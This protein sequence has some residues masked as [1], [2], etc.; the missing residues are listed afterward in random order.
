[1]MMT[2]LPRG[3]MPTER[4]LSG[5]ARPGTPVLRVEPRVAS[6]LRPAC[7]LC[8]KPWARVAL[9]ARCS[10]LS[11]KS[12]GD[13]VGEGASRTPPLAEL[14]GLGQGLLM[15]LQ[16]ERADL[17][18]LDPA[19][20]GGENFLKLETT[21]FDDKGDSFKGKV[22]LGRQTDAIV[23][24]AQVTQV[25]EREKSEG[26]SG[27]DL[28]QELLAIQENG[29]KTIGFFGTRNMGFL[30]QQLVEIL[31]YAMVLTE[32]HIYTSGATG[33]NAAVI[34]GALR[35]EKPDLLTVVLPQSLARQP[36][37]SRDLLKDVANVIE[38][39]EN[40]HMALIDASRLCNER[41]LKEVV[42]VICFAFHDSNLLLETCREAK[43]LRKMVTL[44]YLD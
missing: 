29:P 27:T 21:G 28:M 36:K 35:A 30:H 40:D 23:D 39:P 22:Q 32:N 11:E 20:D 26:G 44:F 42:Q 14:G 10:A 33:T 2:S 43:H 37:E 19:S 38:C 31:S 6:A 9:H 4:M 12:N 41:I 3:M 16:L 34:R 24:G 7:G 15:G 13:G 25:M 1:L 8:A 5:R 17:G 18:A